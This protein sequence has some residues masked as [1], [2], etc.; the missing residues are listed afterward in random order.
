MSDVRNL[1]IIGGGPA[2]PTAAYAARANLEP[3]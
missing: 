2:A 1:I 3:S